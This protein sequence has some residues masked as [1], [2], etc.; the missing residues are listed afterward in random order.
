MRVEGAGVG[1]GVREDFTVAKKNY[2]S[3]YV[4]ITSVF[5][6]VKCELIVHRFVGYK[7]KL[8]KFS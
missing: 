3:F 1:G 4:A 6:A 2:L 8:N 7:I 5:S